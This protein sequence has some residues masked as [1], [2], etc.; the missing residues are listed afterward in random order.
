MSQLDEAWPDPDRSADFWHAGP[1]LF[2]AQISYPT[3]PYRH[4]DLPFVPT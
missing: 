3:T 2:R 1:Q 4:L